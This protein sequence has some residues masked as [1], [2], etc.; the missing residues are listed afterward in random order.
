M[1]ETPTLSFQEFIGRSMPLSQDLEKY[2]KSHPFDKSI[3]QVVG[4]HVVNSPVLFFILSSASGQQG[5]DSKK[6]KISSG[7]IQQLV[8]EAGVRDIFIEG[9]DLEIS[10]GTILPSEA[11]KRLEGGMINGAQHAQ[12]VLSLIP[13]TVIS[14]DERKVYRNFTD[15]FGKWKSGKDKMLKAL[16]ILHVT[17]KRL[18]IYANKAIQTLLVR[19]EA[20]NA[21]RITLN[22]YVRG[23]AQQVKS[24]GLSL[25]TTPEFL[26][27]Y[28]LV[29][30]EQE[31]NF[32]KAKKEIETFSD[33]LMQTLG[34]KD[35]WLRQ[36]VD[37]LS[38]AQTGET[39][40]NQA[41][42]AQM[43]FLSH[44]LANSSSIREL[45]ESLFFRI[46]MYGAYIEGFTALEDPESSQQEQEKAFLSGVLEGPTHLLM[47]LTKKLMAIGSHRETIVPEA[48]DF[49]L[50]AAVFAG[51]DETHIPHLIRYAQYG[52]R[53]R[54]LGTFQLMKEIED[55]ENNLL[56]RTA[57]SG[58]DKGAVGLHA[59]YTVL[60]KRVQLQIDR[61]EM[62]KQYIQEQPPE[63]YTLKIER[64]ALMQK[65][66][67]KESQ[68]AL[69]ILNEMESISREF[70]QE[71]EKRSQA[72][73]VKL[74]TEL[75]KRKID[76]A[77]VYM[78]EQYC[79]S[80]IANLD[81]NTSYVVL[82]PETDRSKVLSLFNGLMRQRK[83]FKGES[84]IIFYRDIED[85]FK[86]AP[87]ILCDSPLC[88]FSAPAIHDRV[89]CLTHPSSQAV[90]Y[91]D[92]CNKYY[93]G[94]ELK[95]VF[96]SNEDFEALLSFDPME[97]FEMIEGKPPFS[98]QCRHCGNF[99]GKGDR[100]IIWNV[101]K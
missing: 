72:M 45:R 65:A 30:S 14:I 32:E 36:T 41:L 40:R 56:K 50:D 85:D 44:Y 76:R 89:V 21:G 2:L 12:V 24:A 18:T 52:N 26:K 74:Q 94:M 13:L 92:T 77:I 96:M 46:A 8:R 87:R 62:V 31:I 16:S 54:A 29:L 97:L 39:P 73:A 27:F 101:S 55:I 42:E 6:E 57:V 51:F 68:T 75:S 93:C 71:S 9:I 67:G 38:P 98:L 25:K 15:V 61:K 35:L 47:L 88:R 20:Y 95:Q 17:L 10:Q 5:I 19:R 28:E 81:Q 99:V 48:Y 64:A 84:D 83:T 78:G 33:R 86:H 34:D 63:N 59:A 7:L 43:E 91:C 82:I 1:I 23:L 22:E 53:Y 37:A 3:C 58:H 80:L 60:S 90:F 11:N 100:T 66:I 70:Y 69:K 79:K 4:P 49:I